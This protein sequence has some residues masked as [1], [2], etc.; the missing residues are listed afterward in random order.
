MSAFG[1][2]FRVHVG[3]LG[4]GLTRLT[5]RCVTSSRRKSTDARFPRERQLPRDRA[6]FHFYVVDF[7]PPKTPLSD[8]FGEEDGPDM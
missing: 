3:L 5:S 7:S 2:V 1:C 6:F 8:R 4:G